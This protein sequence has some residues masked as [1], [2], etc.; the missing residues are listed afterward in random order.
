MADDWEQLT[1]LTGGQSLVVER[2]RLDRS[3]IAI[4]GSF[5]LPPVARLS[6]DDQVFVAA[7]MHCHGSIKRMEEWFGVSYPTIK[8]RLNEIASQ[9]EFS[10]MQ[11]SAAPPSDGDVLQKLGAGEITVDEAEAALKN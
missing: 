5:K 11:R 4:E 3:D 10:E 8:N 2:V 6:A 1:E 9:L 7:F